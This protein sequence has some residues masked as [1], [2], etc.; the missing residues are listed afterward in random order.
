VGEDEE[1]DGDQIDR[2]YGRFRTSARG[3]DKGKEPEEKV[4]DVAGDVALEK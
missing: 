3:S 1:T 4:K 2:G